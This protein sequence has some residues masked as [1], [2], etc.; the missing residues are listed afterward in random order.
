MITPGQDAFYF[1]SDS[2]RDPINTSG[3]WTGWALLRQL[4]CGVGLAPVVGMSPCQKKT[5][6]VIKL[7]QSGNDNVIDTLHIDVTLL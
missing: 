2:L 3:G 4:I 7:D 1:D 6:I 5:N